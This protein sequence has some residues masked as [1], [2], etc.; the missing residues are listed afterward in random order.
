MT[1]LLHSTVGTPCLFMSPPSQVGLSQIKL[2]QRK[3]V[4]V[5]G[6]LLVAGHS[7]L[8]VEQMWAFLQV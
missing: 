3:S 4:F 2:G 5:G 6:I 7:V 8:A 1:V